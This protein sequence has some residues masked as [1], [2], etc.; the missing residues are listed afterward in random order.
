[1][2]FSLSAN[3]Q[4]GL[5]PWLTDADKEIMDTF[6]RS[7]EEGVLTTF[8]GS[9][10]ARLSPLEITYQ[11]QQ[12]DAFHAV[13]LISNRTLKPLKYRIICLVDYR[14]QMIALDNLVSKSHEVTLQPKEQKIFT[15]ATGA[16]NKGSHDFVLLAI[17]E[18]GGPKYD[19]PILSHRANILVKGGGFPLAQHEQLDATP[20]NFLP[21]NGVVFNRAVKAGEF[22]PQMSNLTRNEKYYLHIANVNEHITGYAVLIFADYEQQNF[23]VGDDRGVYYLN[24]AG[25]SAGVVPWATAGEQCSNLFAIVIENPYQT[26]E[27]EPGVMAKTPASVYLSNVLIKK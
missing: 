5:H 20:L 3:A 16:V 12:G 6:T 2:L 21:I 22:S 8:K 10:S 24:L 15:L 23:G 11:I 7:G 4:D 9:P 13:Y 25:K 19:F 27:P 26:M 1:M 14:Q 18:G 17:H